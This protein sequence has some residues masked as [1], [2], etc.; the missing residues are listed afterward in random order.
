MVHTGAFLIRS[1]LSFKKRINFAGLF[2]TAQN[3]A[4]KPVAENK[5]GGI[6]KRVASFCQRCPAFL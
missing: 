2:W 1:A 5:P 4:K 6:S 3:R